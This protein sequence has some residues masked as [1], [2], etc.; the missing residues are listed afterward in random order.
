MTNENVSSSNYFIISLCL[1]ALLGYTCVVSCMTYLMVI[2]NTVPKN[3][4]NLDKT[5]CGFGGFPTNT[6]FY[7]S[8][9]IY[10]SHFYVKD[11]TAFL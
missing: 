6:K 9:R 5:L 11:F 7:L 10:M 2:I 1:F 3:L 4:I 8:I